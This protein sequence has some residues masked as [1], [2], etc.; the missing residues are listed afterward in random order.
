[1]RD[2]PAPAPEAAGRESKAYANYVLGLLFVVYVF[3]FVDRQIMSILL[4]PIKQDLG[5]SD[6]QMGFLTGFA[7]ALFYT[8]A[9]L[10]IARFAD[11]SVRRSVIAAGLA[12]W[13]GMTAASGLAR[14]FAQLAAARVMVGVGEAACSPPAHSLLADYFPPHRRATALSIY[15]MGIHVG[16]L[17]GLVVGGWLNDLY[18]WRVAFYVVG[19]PGLLLAVV[20]RLTVREPRRGLS[21]GAAEEAEVPTTREVFDFLWKLRSFRHLSIASALTA[22]AGYGVATWGPAF[23]VRVHG[24]STTEVGMKLGILLGTAGAAGSILAGFVVDALSKRDAR[25]AL[26]VPAVAAIVSLPFA[27][28][29]LFWPQVDA[30]LIFAFPAF[31]VG[32]MWQ[33]PIFSVTQTLAR[34]RMRSVASAILLFIINLIGLGM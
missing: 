31:L 17:V 4:E 1:M 16:I 26:R 24:I 25:W 7:F 28:L 13:S 29:F 2:A 9:G 34:L 33:G 8:T 3:N 32:A 18:G 15:A 20:V 14:S 23:L 10:P 6:S 19:L 22:F 30:A 21:E 11:R 12:V 27:L 5:A